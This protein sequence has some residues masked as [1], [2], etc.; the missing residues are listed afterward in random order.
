MS[1][2][3]AVISM[4]VGGQVCR[5][6]VAIV[7]GDAPFLISMPF[8]QRMGAVLDLEQGQ[9]TFNKLGGHAESGRLCNWSLCDRSDFWMC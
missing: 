1:L 4:N 6:K 7:A 8:L 5:E 3:S 2:W 9:A